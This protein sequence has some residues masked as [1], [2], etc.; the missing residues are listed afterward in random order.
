MAKDDSIQPL[1]EK[2]FDVA[3]KSGLT[4]E[5]QKKAL[6]RAEGRI[7][8]LISGKEPRKAKPKK[9]A[10]K[11]EKKVKAKKAETPTAE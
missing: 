10:K 2:L 7:M 8:T 5:E 3:S 9:E 6:W 1:A 4:L 11:A